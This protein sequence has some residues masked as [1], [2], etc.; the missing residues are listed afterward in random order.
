[1]AGDS[2]D[3]N[4]E[5]YLRVFRVQTFFSI[6]RYLCSQICPITI[7]PW[8]HD[9]SHTVLA[10]FAPV[11]DASVVHNTGICSIGESWTELGESTFNCCPG[12]VFASINLNLSISCSDGGFNAPAA[13][14]LNRAPEKTQ[15]SPLDSTTFKCSLPIVVAPFLVLM[16]FLLPQKATNRV[17]LGTI[18]FA[19]LLLI[20]TSTEVSPEERRFLQLSTMVTISATFASLVPCIFRSVSKPNTQILEH[21]PKP[22]KVGFVLFL[23]C[24]R[25]T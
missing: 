8:S 1:M 7:G 25:N 13:E 5:P 11:N 20:W 18:V 4:K 9:T 6:F 24:H 22:S 14:A 12:I 19:A 15:T 2:T 17:F 10:T 21:G 3:H 23:I 16:I